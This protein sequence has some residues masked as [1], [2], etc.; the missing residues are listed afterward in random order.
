GGRRRA[1]WTLSVRC[2]QLL[3][4]AVALMLLGA[5][6]PVRLP[7]E[8]DDAYAID[9]NPAGLG[10]MRGAELRLRYA[11]E[12]FSAKGPASPRNS[13]GVYTAGQTFGPLSIGGALDV[14]VDGEDRTGYRLAFA[15]ALR[16]GAL[17]LGTS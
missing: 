17:S 14:Q 15:S 6:N 9:A 4:A 10:F 7:A 16:F 11:H 2:M 13:F 1:A 3:S 8:V 12:D 5:P